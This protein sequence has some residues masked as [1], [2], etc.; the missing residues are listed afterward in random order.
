MEILPFFPLHFLFLPANLRPE[1]ETGKVVNNITGLP[2]LFDN[3]DCHKINGIFHKKQGRKQ[4]GPASYF[5]CLSW[6][7]ISF[8]VCTFLFISM[9]I[10][11]FLCK[12]KV[13]VWA[14][15]WCFHLF[16]SLW[17]DW[18][19]LSITDIHKQTLTKLRQELTHLSQDEW[20]Y[21]PIDQIIGFW[22]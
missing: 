18:I 14:H 17:T 7:W 1:S 22:Y 21:K 9:P 2:A 12:C 6:K 3:P 5:P 10:N 8:H 11:D 13:N 15:L 16:Y 20:M 19:C 4:G